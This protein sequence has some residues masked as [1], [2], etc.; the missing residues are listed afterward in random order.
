MT[1]KEFDKLD[2]QEQ[3]EMLKEVEEQFN[4][5][6]PIVEPKYDDEGNIKNQKEVDN[7]LKKVFPI[8]LSI[9]SLSYAVIKDKC[10]KT[11]VYTNNFVNSLKK[12]KNYKKQ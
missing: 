9:W 10:I 2:K 1:Q 3:I 12:A 8:A 5:D 7:S 11:M 6:L 4:V